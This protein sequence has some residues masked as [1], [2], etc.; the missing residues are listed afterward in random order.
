MELVRKIPSFMVQK[1]LLEVTKGRQALKTWFDARPVRG[2]CPPDLRIPVVVMGH[3]EARNSADDGEV[4]EFSV[5]V[6][7]FL[8][9]TRIQLVDVPPFPALLEALETE[10]EVF[11]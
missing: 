9:P 7:S 10:P 4:T 11:F 1:A 5:V 6:D 8:L 3:I 2:P